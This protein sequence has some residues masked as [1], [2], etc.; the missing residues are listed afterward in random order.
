VL[1]NG[2]I[3]EEGSHSELMEL[4]GHYHRLFTTQASRYIEISKELQS[5]DT[6]ESESEEI[7][8]KVGRHRK[9]R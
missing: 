6:N 1:Q 8:G 7:T 5:E 4:G 3:I 9:N 2:K